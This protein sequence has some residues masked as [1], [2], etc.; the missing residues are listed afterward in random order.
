[1]PSLLGHLC[2]WPAS[3]IA[4]LRHLCAIDNDHH[5]LPLSPP[6]PPSSS[7]AAVKFYVFLFFFLDTAYV[8]TDNTV[9]TLHCLPGPPKAPSQGKEVLVQLLSEDPII[10]RLHSYVY[11]FY[12][13][14]YTSLMCFYCLPPHSLNEDERSCDI[15]MFAYK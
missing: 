8:C 12:Y 6:P 5:H 15:K 10:G 9:G 4:L 1:M 3:V 7:F 13:S 2:I 14:R 11:F